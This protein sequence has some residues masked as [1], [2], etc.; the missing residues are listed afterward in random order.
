MTCEKNL[1][2]PLN[3]SKGL[4]QCHTQPIASCKNW[5]CTHW[6][7]QGILIETYKILKYQMHMVTVIYTKVIN[8]SNT[9]GRDH[10]WKLNKQS[11]TTPRLTFFTQHAHMSA[12][13]VLCQIMW[14]LH[15]ST[16]PILDYGFQQRPSKLS[17]WL[18]CI[19]YQA[20]Y[21]IKL[22]S[23]LGLL[24]FVMHRFSTMTMASLLWEQWLV[25]SKCHM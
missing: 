9:R 14:C 20:M 13:N 17:S 2:V 6:C 5:D 4:K 8:L 11:R 12:W 3:L 23:I 15:P 22:Y 25:H 7:T 1:S 19:H 24:N 10:S 16:R 21:N 18:F